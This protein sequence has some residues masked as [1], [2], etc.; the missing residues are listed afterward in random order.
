MTISMMALTR[1]LALK[2]S[3]QMT[4]AAAMTVTTGRKKTVRKKTRP[5]IFRLT[6]IANHRA[7]AV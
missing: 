4:A 1:P 3:V 2:S 5:G 6:R 7:K